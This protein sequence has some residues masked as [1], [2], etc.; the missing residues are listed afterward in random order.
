MNTEA[1]QATPA[2]VAATAFGAET[3]KHRKV[4]WDIT[5]RD[6]VVPVPV[7]PYYKADGK[8]GFRATID[9]G[10]FMCWPEGMPA[11]L[12][13]EGTLTVSVPTNS[14]TEPE[15]DEERG[16]VKLPCKTKFVRFEA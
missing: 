5:Y 7:R 16:I 10:T 3:N 4:S 13:G 1:I 11:G 12:T 9:A 8:C 14:D 2:P 15:F 6:F